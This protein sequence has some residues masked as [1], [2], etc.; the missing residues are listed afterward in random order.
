MMEKD[1]RRV[2]EI[3]TNRMMNKLREDVEKLQAY[4]AI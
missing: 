4:V 1:T 2:S 3:L